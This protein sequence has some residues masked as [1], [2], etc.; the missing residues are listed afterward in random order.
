MILALPSSAAL[1]HVLTTVGLFGLV[2]AVY[3]LAIGLLC[4]ALSYRNRDTVIW[5]DSV[6]HDVESCPSCNP[7]RARYGGR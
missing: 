7:P 2:V 1:A 3:F 4:R 6:G 5:L